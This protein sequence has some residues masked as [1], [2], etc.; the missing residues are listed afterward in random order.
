MMH[1]DMF[2]YMC[3][4]AEEVLVVIRRSF[5]LHLRPMR[6]L[7]M[8]QICI[9]VKVRVKA[10]RQVKKLLLSIDRVQFGEVIGFGI[11]FEGRD[12][13]IQEIYGCEKRRK[14]KEPSN[15]VLH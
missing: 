15:F 11:Q 10:D 2:T 14:F 9:S 12:A 4:R 13:R 3:T 6:R 7:E 5:V 1:S 8:V